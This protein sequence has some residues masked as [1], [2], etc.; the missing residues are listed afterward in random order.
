M[1]TSIF[2]RKCGD[3][4]D[5]L[6]N[7]RSDRLYGNRDGSSM[8]T[9]LGGYIEC[10]QNRSGYDLPRCDP[11]IR[12][13]CGRSRATSRHA[14]TP[15]DFAC[16]SASTYS[17]AAGRVDRKFRTILT[18]RT[19]GGKPSETNDPEYDIVCGCHRSNST[20]LSHAWNQRKKLTMPTNMLTTEDLLH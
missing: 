13:K 14:H 15:Q 12:H 8:R 16:A 11:I 10:E 5:L 3:C 1:E 18:E 2:L 20:A 7:G 19:F 9:G 4:A 17:R 6:T